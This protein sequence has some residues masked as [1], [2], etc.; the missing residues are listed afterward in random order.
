MSL[1]FDFDALLALGSAELKDRGISISL[2]D[3]KQLSCRLHRAG[4][5]G[6]AQYSGRL[7][8]GLEFG[9]SEEAVVAK[10]GVPIVAIGGTRTRRWLRYFRKEIQLDEKGTVELV[11]I[12]A[13]EPLI[14]VEPHA[15]S[16][17]D[18]LIGAKRIVNWKRAIKVGTEAENSCAVYKCKDCA[19]YFAIYPGSGVPI[20]LSQ[21]DVDQLDFKKA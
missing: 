9:D 19:T 5:Q 8:G 4:H 12:Y 20:D 16:D 18:C 2:E 21:A 14:E 17:C 11:S 7:P 15:V 6:H 1:D 3:P 10:L 13:A